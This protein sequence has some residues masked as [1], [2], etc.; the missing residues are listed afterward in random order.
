MNIV[1]N[2]YMN[3]ISFPKG[4]EKSP[5]GGGFRGRFTKVIIINMTLN[6]RT[7]SPLLLR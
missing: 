1:Y 7:N 2:A 4:K 6:P 3:A 5:F